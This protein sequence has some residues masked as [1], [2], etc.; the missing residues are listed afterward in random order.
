MGDSLSN[1]D[2]VYGAIDLGSNYCRL[3]LARPNFNGFTV[4]D[5]FSRIVRLGE[6]VRYNRILSDR[7]MERAIEALKKC[8]AKLSEYD[9]SRFRG[10]VTAACREAKNCELFLNRVYVETGI[11]LNIVSDAEEAY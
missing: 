5:S 3:L 11:K 10:V 2:R 1:I 6:G 4:V 8:R 7:A 9:V